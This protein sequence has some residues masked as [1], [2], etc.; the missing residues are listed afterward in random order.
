[1]HQEARKGCGCRNQPETQQYSDPTLPIIHYPSPCNQSYVPACE[2]HC[3]PRECQTVTD[4]SSGALLR[5]RRVTVD[6]LRR[7]R[8]ENRLQ[9]LRLL[10]FPVNTLVSSVLLEKHDY[11][12]RI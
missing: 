5:T 1:M 3:S 2:R 10:Y 9:D 7:E 11:I 4:T 6:Y 8:K 12:L